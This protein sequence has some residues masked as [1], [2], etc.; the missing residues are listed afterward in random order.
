MTVDVIAS[1]LVFTVQPGGSLSG[2]ALLAQPVLSALDDYGNLDTGFSDLV[3]LSENAPG[4]LENNTA[5]PVGGITTFTNLT[6]VALAD[7]ETFI[8]TANDSP[9]GREGDLDP[10]QLKAV[11]ADSFNDPPQLDFPPLTLA[12]DSPFILNLTDLVSDLDDAEFS[13]TF[14]SVHIAVAVEGD[15]RHPDPGPG[16]V[17][18]RFSVCRGE[19]SQRS[20]CHDP[21][22]RRGQPNC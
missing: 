22:C 18:N 6:Y 4:V 14:N 21:G 8:L 15:L 7:N 19:R 17:W 5:T 20:I 11:L 9:E 2:L 13:W 3:T 1:R 12:E 10:V 16:M